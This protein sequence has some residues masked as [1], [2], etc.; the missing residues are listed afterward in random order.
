[1]RAL[2]EVQS[3]W[4]GY[5]S[6]APNGRALGLTYAVLREAQAMKMRPV[7]AVRSAVGG[8][9][10][11][12]AEHGQYAHVEVFNDGALVAAIKRPTIAREICEFDESGIREVLATI[13]SS[14]G[15]YNP[16][17]HIHV[18]Y[19]AGIILG[20]ATLLHWAIALVAVVASAYLWTTAERAAVRTCRYRSTATF[21]EEKRS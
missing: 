9:L 12:F 3:N 5:G 19:G 10:I 1:M 14:E 20:A 17:T 11:R 18:A 4:N 13:K 2:A 15:T 7:S 6:P 16:S 21:G 8:V